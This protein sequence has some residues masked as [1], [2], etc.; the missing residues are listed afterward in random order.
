[1]SKFFSSANLSFLFQISLKG[2]ICLNVYEILFPANEKYQGMI[3]LAVLNKKKEMKSLGSYYPK[4]LPERIENLKIMKSM[5]YYITA[6]STF[7]FTQRRSENIFSLNNIVLDFDIHERMNPYLREELIEE[8]VWRAKR[9]LFFIQGE[10]KVPIPNV[11]HKT[12]RGCQLWW[13]IHSTSEKLLF[14]YYRII[15]CFGFIFYDFLSEYPELEE[16]IEIDISASKNKVGLFRLFDTFNTHTKT[17]TETEILHKNGFDI[18]ELNKSL[19]E[20]PVI[21]EYLIKKEQRKSNYEKKNQSATKGKKT[22]YQRGYY[23]ALHRKRLAFIKWW[24]LELDDIVGKRDILIYYGFNAAKEIMSTLEAEKWCNNLND[25]FEEPLDSIEYIFKEIQNP[26]HIRS[27]VFFEKLGASEE[28]IKRFEK[29]YSKHSVNLTRN[30]EIQKRKK[31]KDKQKEIARALLKIGE[32]YKT[33]SEKVG[34]STSTIYR[35]A[36]ENGNKKTEEKPWEILGIS[37]ATYY[38]RKKL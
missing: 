32:S 16:Y 3:H 19:Q 5:N 8:F 15:E 22:Q 24:S 21:K 37:R 18:N 26:F 27:N 35:L 28:D 6:N 20:H 33:I 29:E 23:D 9:D 38:R 2:V 17:K 4:D 13:H 11:I 25:S 7:P 31:L 30:M 34:L 14:L 1:M 12:G 36:K 10:F